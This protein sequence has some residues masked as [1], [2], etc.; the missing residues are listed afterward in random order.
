M[1]LI[2]CGCMLIISHSTYY[3]YNDWWI[4]GRSKEEIRE[5]YGEFDISCGRARGYYIYYDDKMIMPDQLEHYY[6]I[7]F[8]ENGAAKKVYDA[9]TPG[10]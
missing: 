5:R 2:T 9:P 10:G 8:D 7:E 6:W 4:V 3:K 1:V